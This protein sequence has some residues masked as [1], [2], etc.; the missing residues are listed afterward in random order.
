MLRRSD[1]ATGEPQL[2]ERAEV[3]EI[4]DAIWD[5]EAVCTEQRCVGR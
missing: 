3:I 5:T 2:D 1:A 4:R